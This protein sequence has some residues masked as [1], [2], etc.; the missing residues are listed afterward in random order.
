VGEW[1]LESELSAWNVLNGRTGRFERFGKLKW[2]AKLELR[3]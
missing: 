2:S 3:L 1:I